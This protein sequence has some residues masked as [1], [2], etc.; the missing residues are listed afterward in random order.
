MGMA[1]EKRERKQ[2]IGLDPQNTNW[3]NDK[4]KVSMPSLCPLISRLDSKCSK[5]WVGQT[6]KD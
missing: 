2:Y 6:A 5:K 1:Q 4:S 3:A